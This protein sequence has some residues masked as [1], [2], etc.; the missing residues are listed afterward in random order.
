M[1]G[2]A[3]H[4]LC[5]NGEQCYLTRDT[6]V[7]VPAAFGGKP[8]EKTLSRGVAKRCSGMCISERYDLEFGNGILGKMETRGK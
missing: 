4:K 1:G 7:S 3:A 6:M 5:P 8:G 2:L